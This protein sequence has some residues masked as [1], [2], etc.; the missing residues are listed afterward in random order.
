MSTVHLNNLTVRFGDVTAVDRVTMTLQQG[1]FVVLLGPSGCGKTT[2]LRCIA[3]LQECTSGEIRFDDRV[4]TGLSAA[5]R[6]IGMVFQFVSLYPHLSVRGNIAF[7]LRAR[8]LPRA[9]IATRIERVAKVFKIEDILG[10]Y[11]GGL[12]PG[13]RQKVAIAR[14]VVREPDVLLLDEPLSGVEEQ[15]R[16]EMRWELRQL[17]KEL[18]ISSVYVTHDQR[19]AM[20]LADRVVLMRDGRIVQIGSPA[21]LF[22]RPAD[23]FAA[24]FVG[25]PSMNFLSIALDE[26]GFCIP[27]SPPLHVEAPEAVVDACRAR[28]LKEIVLGVRPHLVE[29]T[30]G[31]ANGP[32][33]WPARLIDAVPIGR[34][35]QA[36][37]AVAGQMVKAE[38]AAGVDLLGVRCVRLRPEHCFFF[39]P[40]G[41]RLG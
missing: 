22:D 31:P 24:F 12:P 38:M 16:E 19:E 26:D 17:Q 6:N 20:S 35:V 33:V 30:H 21:E 8:G 40:D 27:A 11:V 28:G 36:D 25:S 18:G 9:E 7:P 32:N 13:A 37:F 14:A 15:Y 29:P 39:A 41:S 3:G 10:Q 1:E 23:R 4:V 34:D 5:E 2:T